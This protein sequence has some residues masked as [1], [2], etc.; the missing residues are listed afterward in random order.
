MIDQQLAIQ[1]PHPG[2]E[3]RPTGEVTAWNR[4]MHRR[5]FLRSH[6][7][8]VDG[9]GQLQS[10]NFAFWGEWE[11][12]SRVVERWAPSG[13]LPQFLHEPFLD[14]PIDGSWRQ[15]TDPLVFG[16]T[17]IYSNCRQPTDRKLRELATGSLLLF[18]SG[19]SEGFVLDT[20]LVISD[21]PA[22]LYQVG[23]NDVAPDRPELTQL[24]FD[25]MGPGDVGPPL[26][27]RLYQGATH[28]QPVQGMYS[29]TPC[30]P[31]D[32][33]DVRFERPLLDLPGI[34]SPTLRMKARTIPVPAA[35]IPNVWQRVVDVVADAGLCRG[36]RL[37]LPDAAGQPDVSG[38]VPA[39]PR[40]S[41]C[42]G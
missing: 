36:V 4:G 19:Q 9:D 6:G 12:D 33:E 25:P 17:F 27:C 8:Y 31:V 22:P 29:F 37:D 18:G 15:N 13:R 2:P 26:H 34:I 11:P 35:D 14:P 41:G 21:S 7:Q 10:G 20:V 32:G 3:H 16:K 42:A 23:E 28:D 24:I 39:A 5:K 30:R 38:P 1:F 40:T